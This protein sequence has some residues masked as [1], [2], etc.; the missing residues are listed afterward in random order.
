MT[1]KPPHGG[2]FFGCCHC[3]SY[4]RGKPT[5]KKR[6]GMILTRRTSPAAIVGKHGDRQFDYAQKILLAVE[7]AEAPRQLAGMPSELCAVQAARY[8]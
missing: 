6:A 5:T 3:A 8:P 1:Q 7:F 4:R 2:F